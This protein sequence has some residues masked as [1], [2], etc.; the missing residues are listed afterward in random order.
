MISDVIKWLKQHSDLNWALADQGMVSASNFLTG[1]LLARYLGIGE[2]GRFTLVWLVAEFFHSIQH[3]LIIVPMMSMGPK[4][5]ASKKRKY[6]GAVMAQQACLAVVVTVVLLFGAIATAPLAPEWHLERLA[7]PLS[8]AVFT[9]QT[10]NFLRRYF[11]TQ[12]RGLAAFLCDMIRYP[13]QVMILVWL[14]HGQDMDTVDAL[15]VITAASGIASAVAVAGVQRPEWN[16]AV[17]LEVTR[18]HWDLAKWL[19]CSTMLRYATQNLFIMV[20]GAVLGAS[21][22]G[23]LRVTQ[24]LVGAVNV[25]LLGLENVIPI[26]AAERLKE[27]GREGL[28]AYLK[29]FALLGGVGTGIIVGIAAAA[30][31]FWLELLF[32]AEF[33]GYAHLVFWWS[34]TFMLIFLDRPAG[35]GLRALE[36]TRPFFWSQFW[37]VVFAAMF[38]YPLIQNFGL[39]GA[40]TGIVLMT[41][42]R[43]SIVNVAYMR[44]VS[45]LA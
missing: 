29:R 20:S 25:L 15:W 6:F 17:L 10:Q 35:Y 31:T 39:V 11:F 42:L 4:Q 16:K 43:T 44:N 45:R 26:R 9:F 37:A 23:G 7:L 30:P 13:G 36:Q 24:I 5:A 40:M 21:A 2:F 34:A 3:A 1:I 22:A 38:S 27:G 33:V 18:G 8:C 14:F 32:G 41:F 19:V 12:T 28:V